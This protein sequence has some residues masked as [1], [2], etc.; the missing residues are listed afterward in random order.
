MIL[1]TLEGKFIVQKKKHTINNEASRFF[2]DGDS[3]ALGHP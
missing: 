2:Y 3:A 1:L